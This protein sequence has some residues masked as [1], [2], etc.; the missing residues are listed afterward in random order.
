MQE[1]FKAARD[2]DWSANDDGTVSVAGQTLTA[3]EFQLGIE[4]PDDITAA[5]LRSND[6]VVVLDTELTPD[7]EAEGLARDVVRQVQQARKD[8]DLD[9]TDRID[10]WIDIASDDTLAALDAFDGYV[11]EQVLAVDLTTGTP[12][13]DVDVHDAEVDGQ[14][15]R[16]GLRVRTDL[17]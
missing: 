4:S 11:R 16:F 8:E 2:G 3:E 17:G 6:A 12:P 10:L 14:P 1:V 5:A 15:L 7:L 9:V 13:D